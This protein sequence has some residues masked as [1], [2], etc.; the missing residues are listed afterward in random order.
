MHDQ[1]AWLRLQ[2]ASTLRKLFLASRKLAFEGCSLL[3]DRI[4]TELST[5][6]PEH[7]GNPLALIVQGALERATAIL[8]KWD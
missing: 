6:M 3:V 7:L 4:N 1:R 8:R 2:L 5:T